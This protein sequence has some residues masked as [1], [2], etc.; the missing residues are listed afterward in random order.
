MYVQRNNEARSSND[1]CGGKAIRIAYCECV[2]VALGIQHATRMC[3]TVIC[4]LPYST[5]FFPY[6]LINGKILEKKLL[7]TNCVF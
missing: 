4:G 7:N 3:H 6:Y 2:F 1:C 5:I